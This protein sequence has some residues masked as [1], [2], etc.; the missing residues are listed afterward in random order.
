[1][2]GA[3]VFFVGD[4]AGPGVESLPDERRCL[5]RFLDHLRAA[6]PDVLTG[7]NVGDFDVGVLLRVCRRLGLRCALGRTDEEAEIRRDQ[8]FTREPRV[9]LAG[10]QVLGGLAL[11]R[12]AFIHLDDYRLPTAAPV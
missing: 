7:W 9:I 2:G 6:D 4:A 11:L 12:S 3:H 10:R 8:S 1:E 5:T